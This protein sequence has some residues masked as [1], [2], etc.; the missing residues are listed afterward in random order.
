MF[1][2]VLPL[3]PLVVVLR[4]SLFASAEQDRRSNCDRAQG[5]FQ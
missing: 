1:P 2:E 5:A 4:E 3:M